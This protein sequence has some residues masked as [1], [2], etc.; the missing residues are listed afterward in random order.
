MRAKTRENVRVPGGRIRR[1][2][3]SRRP[4][5]M[6]SVVWQQ[7]VANSAIAA[8]ESCPAAVNAQ[9]ASAST[10][11]SGCHRPSRERGSG[12]RASQSRRQQQEVSSPAARTA[13]SSSAGT[14]IREDSSTGT[15]LSEVV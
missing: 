4:L 8:G 6:A 5:R 12:T 3:G 9:I 11:S 14:S 2:Q 7:P 10:N 13:G 15:G 1:V